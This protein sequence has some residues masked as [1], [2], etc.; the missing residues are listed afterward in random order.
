[1]FPIGFRNERASSLWSPCAHPQLATIFYVFAQRHHLL[2]EEPSRNCTQQQRKCTGRG[3][4]RNGQA[5]T[6][7]QRHC[8]PCTQTNATILQLD[9]YFIWVMKRD[10]NVANAPSPDCPPDCSRS[11]GLLSYRSIN[12]Q[13]KAR[14][15][16]MQIDNKP[17]T[18]KPQRA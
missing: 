11:E 3:S 1:M 6:H 8:Q 17:T 15:C 12:L 13:F 10:M 9:D 7:F 4:Q 18:R 14:R 16:S 2:Q 5:T